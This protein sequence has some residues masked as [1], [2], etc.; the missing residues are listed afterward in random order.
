[1]WIIHF[2]LYNPDQVECLSFF[3]CKKLT[4]EFCVFLLFVQYRYCPICNTNQHMY[5]TKYFLRYYVHQPR[6]AHSFGPLPSNLKVVYSSPIGARICQF[7]FFFSLPRTLRMSTEP[8]QMQSSMTFIW[9]N[10]CRCIERMIIWK[11][12]AAV[13]VPSISAD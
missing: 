7:I 9:G 2:K 12:M 6:L 11:K 3:V 5:N 10:A 1:M 8:I 13:L 4:Q